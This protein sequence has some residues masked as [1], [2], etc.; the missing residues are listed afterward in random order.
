MA[1]ARSA[2]TGLWTLNRYAQP[3]GPS[4][5][6]LD[7]P[8]LRNLEGVYPLPDVADMRFRPA[9]LRPPRCFGVN[10]ARLHAPILPVPPFASDQ[11]RRWPALSLRMESERRSGTAGWDMTAS[12]NAKLRRS[13]AKRLCVQI[14]FS[15]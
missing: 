10:P 15:G 2:G 6:A 8:G 11:Q 14:T 1:A 9:Q 12:G 13:C 3:S 5:L 4:G 7:R